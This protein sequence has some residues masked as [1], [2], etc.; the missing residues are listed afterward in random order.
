M[1]KREKG[2]LKH[3]PEGDDVQRGFASP[4][5]YLGELDSQFAESLAA[6]GDNLRTW[7]QHQRTRLTAQRQTL[8]DEERARRDARIRRHVA[9]VQDL[10]GSCT[11]FCWPLPGE[12]DLMPLVR[13]LIETGNTAALAVIAGK[14]QPLEFWQ[15]DTSTRMVTGSVWE[16]PVP[17]HAVSASP[18]VILVPLLGFD[19][20]GHRLGNGGGYF[21]RTLASLNPKPLCVGYGYEEG[22]LETIYP[23]PWDIPMDLIVTER[24]IA[25]D[26]SRIISAGEL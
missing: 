26:A 22:R 23:Q 5:C 12:P 7:R 16:M 10:Q 21:D 6:T 24:G 14:Y 15:W 8:T 9:S 25:V 19:S 2:A 20:A 17:A 18:D 11:G 13:Q 3:K 1:V 4:P